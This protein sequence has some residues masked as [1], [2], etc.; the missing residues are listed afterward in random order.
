MRSELAFDTAGVIGGGT[1]GVGIAYVLAHS[2]ARVWLVEP[3][4]AQ[5]DRALVALTRQAQKAAARHEPPDGLAGLLDRVVRVA[6]IER[7]PLSCD[8]VIEA[9]PEQ[10]GLKRSVLRVAEGRAPGLLGTNT[11]GIPIGSLAESLTEPA[12][13]VGLHFFNPVW[14][15]PLLEVVR[16]EATSQET[17][18]RALLLAAQLGKEPIV[19]RD[20]PGFATSRLGVGLALEAIRMLADGVASADDIDKA[21]ELGYGH[22]MGPLR[23]T[24][25]VG[26]DVRLAIAR[27]LQ[28]A[29][30]DRF[31][32]PQLLVDKVAAGELGRKSGRGFY[33][34]TQAAGA[35]ASVGEEADS[36]CST[37]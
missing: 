6:S 27:N 9:V 21:M 19:V 20:L 10:L 2:R 36:A 23:L 1:M 11:S 25:L 31:A 7:M 17:V 22:P 4:D 28:Q 29:Y 33:G 15:M 30:G 14:S 37:A 18:D 13:L 24:D 3:D 35:T 12:A 16:A 32:P 5:A 34:W 26:L 8:V